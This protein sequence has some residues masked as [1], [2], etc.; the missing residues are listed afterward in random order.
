MKA[1]AV[2]YNVLK[3][4]ANVAALVVANGVNRIY[5]VIL[6]QE[7][8]YPAIL[9]KAVSSERIQG[10]H[11]DP[12]YARV[13]VQVTCI[14]RAFD[15][16][17]DLAEKARIALERHGSAVTGTTIAGVTVYDIFMGS[18]AQTYEPEI[19]CYAIATDYTVVHAE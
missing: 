1:E 2:I 15:D 7:P 11:S 10:V 17:L 5:P 19:E 12:G 8:I 6:P 4:N 9:Y 18:E 3:D 13:R 16:A 14:A